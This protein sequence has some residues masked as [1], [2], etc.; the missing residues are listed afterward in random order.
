MQ[1]QRNKEQESLFLGLEGA[2]YTDSPLV[3]TESSK[4][5]DFSLAELQ[6][7]PF[8]WAVTGQEASLLPPADVVM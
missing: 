4:C 2:L 6:R 8:D 1:V 5:D 3:E 7:S